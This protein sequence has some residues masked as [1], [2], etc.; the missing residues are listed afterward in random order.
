MNF[1]IGNSA[2]E[3]KEQD[4]NVEFSDE[5]IDFI[6]KLNEKVSFDMQRLCE[7][8]PYDDVEIS[9]NDVKQIISICEHILDNKLLYD[10]DE[11]N[12]GNQ[13]LKDL[14]ELAQKALLKGLGLI[15]VGD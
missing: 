8:N 5:L 14:A 1:Y 13:M 10:Y 6:Y 9:K 3:V 15:S 12:K 7:I 2:D 11:P 4:C